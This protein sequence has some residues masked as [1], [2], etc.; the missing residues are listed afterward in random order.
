[1]KPDFNLCDCCGARVNDRGFFIATDRTTDGSG[2]Y[3]ADGRHVDLCQTCA[4]NVIQLL[5]QRDVGSGGPVL[6]P[7]YDMGVKALAIIDKIAAK[8]KRGRP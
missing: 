5:C 6:V 7:D 8:A 3:S 2:S 4:V 1:M